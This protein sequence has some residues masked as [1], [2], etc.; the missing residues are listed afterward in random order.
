MVTIYQFLQNIRQPYTVAEI[1]R[2]DFPL[3]LP[4]ATTQANNY[5]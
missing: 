2:E 1:K 4:Y 5:E 3:I